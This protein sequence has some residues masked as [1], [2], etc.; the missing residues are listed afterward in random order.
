MSSMFQN[1]SG[2]VGHA[3]KHLHTTTRRV[4]NTI[5]VTTDRVLPPQQRKEIAQNLRFFAE[6]NPK[7]AAFLGAQAALAGLPLILFLA[8]AT[9]TLLVSLITCLLLGILAA[10]AFTFVVVG[11]ALIF[12]VPTVFI[13]SCSATFIFIWALV[14]YTI[15]RRL[16][17][18]EAPSK[19]GTRMGDKLHG[20]TVDKT[21]LRIGGAA[22]Q[23]QVEKNEGKDSTKKSGAEGGEDRY[24]GSRQGIGGDVNGVD[25]HHATLEWERKWDSEVQQQPVVPEVENPYEVL[26]TETEIS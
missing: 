9:T 14:G 21:G 15:L 11:F 10:L 26:K 3:G 5:Q 7:L 19:R 24:N 12:V 16:N 1:A 6:D 22:D 2:V 18:G 8:F 13:A 25:D 20:L 23:T 17:G 4:G